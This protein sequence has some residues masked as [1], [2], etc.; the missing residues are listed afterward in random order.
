MDGG[1]IRAR[2]NIG[3][4]AAIDTVGRLDAI[5]GIKPAVRQDQWR[6]SY[7]R[8]I[9]RTGRNN[10]KTGGLKHGMFAVGADIQAH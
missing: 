9:L 8:E 1:L 4:D 10:N 2:L 7:R 5:H 3:S 6:I